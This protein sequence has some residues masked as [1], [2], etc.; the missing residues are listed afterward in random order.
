LLI[1]LQQAGRI[2]AG[3]WGVRDLTERLDSGKV[4][5]LLGAN[6]AGKSTL[7][8]LIAGWLPLS[9]GRILLDEGPMRPTATHLRRK[10]FLLDELSAK[11]RQGPT[12]PL[13]ELCRSIEDYQA[14]HP[15]VEDE[16]A[17]W[18]ERLDVVSVCKRDSQSMSKGQAYKIAMIGL[19]VIRPPVWLLD[20]PFSA[21]LDAAGLQTLETEIRTHANQGG[22][23]IFSSQ[24][25]EHARRLADWA[26]VLDEG[27]L[28]WSAPPKQL[29]TLTDQTS[30]SLRAVL[31][32]LGPG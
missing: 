11:P 20:E 31:Q 26:L 5:A 18:F 4:Y 6:G 21:G 15:Q 14:D 23:V 29:P 24:W 12:R 3:T 19:F 8:R 1:E 9:H 17:E 13:Q 28:A 27:R 22:I 7:L 2:F 16:V 10:V 25:P 30:P 32:G